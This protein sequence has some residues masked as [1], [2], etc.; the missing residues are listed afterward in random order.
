M[1]TVQSS[2]ELIARVR[3]AYASDTPIYP[4]GGGTVVGFG[5]PMRGGI[6]LPLTTCD[7]VVDYPARDMTITVEAGVTMQSLAST[8]A[9]QQQRLPV[10][11][12][13]AERA[14]I[15]GMVAT[16]FSG[17]RRYG[18][19]T[20]RD[21]VIGISAV[22]GR[23]TAFKAGGRVVKNVAGYDFC[24]LLTGSLGTLAVITQVTLKVKPIPEADA[25][26]IAS[27]RS[28]DELAQQLS[29]LA[30]SSVLPVAIDVIAGD[31]W[32]SLPGDA[33]GVGKL[34]VGLEG[35]DAEV[36]WMIEQLATEWRAW[37]TDE[38]RVVRD[39][40]HTAA[41]WGVLTNAMS[42]RNGDALVV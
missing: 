22:D 4:L 1:A 3:E 31:G 7:C 15:G 21:Y 8:L 29:A 35:T 13:H 10:D 18:H 39:R 34:I 2:D 26:L 20:M 27:P 5:R 17:S 40:T 38:P 33:S 37:S 24:K 9:A 28:Y 36:A 19:G 12:P 16:A 23:G 41:I 6:E 32:P 14:T 11:A 42:D 25:F 30:V